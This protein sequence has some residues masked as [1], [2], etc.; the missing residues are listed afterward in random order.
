MKK[1]HHLWQ[2]AMAHKFLTALVAVL[3]LFG[4]Y[5]WYQKATS[6]PAEAR[7]V[8]AAAAKGLLISSVSGTGQVSASNQVDVKPKAS[9]DVVVVAVAQGQRVYAGQLIAQLDTTD[10]QKSV[11]DA[12]ANL[13]SAQLSM[14]K[15]KQSSADID[16]ILESAF[17]DISN[18]FLDFPTVISNAQD[19][20]V[21]STLNPRNQDN[22]GFYKDFVG[23]ADDRNYQKALLF[24]NAASSDYVTARA[25]YD[26][27]FLAYKNTTRYSDAAAI[28]VLLTKTIA[29]S[30]SL[31]QVLKSEQN[32]LDYLTD[33]GIT[34]GKTLPTLAGTYKTTLRTNIGLVNGHLSNLS[35]TDNAIANAPLDIRSQELTV[36]QRENSLADAKDAL[37]NYYVRAPFAG[38]IAKLS[39]KRGDPVSSG[40]VVATVITTQKI[41]E[42]TLN[43]VDI[44]K[45]AVG[46]KATL[47]FDAS[48]N[49]TIT[50]LVSQIDSIGTVS[51]GVVTYKVGITFDTQ[52][53]SVK[54]GMSVSAAVITAAKQ[55]V[56]LIPNAAVKLQGDASYVET[57]DAY[58]TSAPQA[59]MSQGIASP[60]LPA[61]QTVTIGSSNDT[62]TEII[63]GLNEGDLVI[64]RTIAA[65]AATTATTQTGGLGGLR[66]PGVTGGATRGAT[67]R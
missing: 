37:A 16:S 49:L 32:L 20:I 67:G 28:Q 33:Y 23:Q 65:S 7:Y 55:D 40:T 12:Q 15:L 22:V 11:R 35:S 63:S 43:E 53:D 3:L 60:V 25:D 47:T 50:G 24:I 26:A 48:P 52:D 41:A 21:G 6:V 51:Q 44:A 61:R 1:L 31:A 17:A 9:G 58:K 39:V 34:Y 30:K 54:P 38:V 4:G 56:L 64:V 14:E 10:A 57:L 13:E 36:A 29:A 42:I 27:A 62:M 2:K 8:L 59:A 66:I 45:V 46:Q 19:V 5:F 18:S